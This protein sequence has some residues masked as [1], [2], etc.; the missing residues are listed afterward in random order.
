MRALAVHRMASLGCG[1]VS[2]RTSLCSLRLCGERSLSTSRHRCSCSVPRARQRPRERLRGA[3]RLSYLCVS[4]LCRASD[5]PLRRARLASGLAGGVDL[6]RCCATSLGRALGSSAFGRR[7]SGCLA[8]LGASCGTSHANLLAFA[9]N[10]VATRRHVAGLLHLHTRRSAARRRASVPADV[11]SF[12]SPF[13]FLASVRGVEHVAGQRAVVPSI[14]PMPTRLH[15]TRTIPRKL[16]N[17]AR[18]A[19]PLA[20]HD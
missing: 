7:A 6:E 12:P 10:R 19:R 17:R 5:G 1:F 3:C 14:G 4:V 8:G 20:G 2:S 18:E 15:F 11:R 16:L 9:S 13:T